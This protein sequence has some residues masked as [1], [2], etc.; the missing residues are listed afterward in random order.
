MKNSITQSN[1][2]K[3]LDWSYDKSINGI[4][5]K[6]AE[7]VALEYK[8]KYHDPEICIKHVIHSVELKTSTGGFVTGFG[9]LLTLPVTVPADVT[10]VIYNQLK[11]IA[12]IAIL[13]GY[14]THDEEVRSLA[15]V[16]LTG[17]TLADFAK[18]SGIV[19]GNKIGIGVIKKMP[20][21]SLTKINQAV[22]FRM[23]T[24]FGKTGAINLGKGVPV[25]GALVGASFDGLSIRI[26]ASVTKKN[27]VLE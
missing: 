6:S 11:M 21:K 1:M 27:F 9:G 24:K 14:D 26:V 19:I 22:G 10:A 2:Q 7:N 23:V 5:G 20:G 17:M 13:R 25:I 12:I 3:V 18:K 15:Y 16:C 8:N 4:S